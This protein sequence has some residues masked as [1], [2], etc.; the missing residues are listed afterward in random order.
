MAVRRRA[1]CLQI[2][3]KKLIILYRVNDARC[4]KQ[5]IEF[6]PVRLEA[7]CLSS[8]ASTIARLRIDSLSLEAPLPSGL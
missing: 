8:I 1:L 5:R 7:L 4:G 2:S 6:A 3:L